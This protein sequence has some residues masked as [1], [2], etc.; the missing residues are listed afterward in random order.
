M[1]LNGPLTF[2]PIL[3]LVLGTSALKLEEEEPRQKRLFSLF[4]VVR[5]RNEPCSGG[6]LDNIGTCMSSTECVSAGG[7]TIGNCAAGFGICCGFSIVGC[8][9]TVTQNCTVIRNEGFPSPTTETDK[10]C[11]YNFNRIDSNICQMR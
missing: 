8:G 5:F 11:T 7:N 4:N 3:L 9:G 10:T 1:K 6:R 2:V